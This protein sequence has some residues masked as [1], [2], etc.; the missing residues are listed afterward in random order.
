MGK[1]VDTFP[2]ARFYKTDLH[3]HTSASKCWR[4]QRDA[5]S[6]KRLFQSL[7]TNGIEVVAITDHNSVEN[8]DEACNVAH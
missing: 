4:D 1:T 3:I 5:G 6:L 8:L 2:G 7:K